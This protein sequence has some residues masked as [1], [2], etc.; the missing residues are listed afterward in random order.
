MSAAK[1]HPE[2]AAAMV[3]QP[4]GEPV[5]YVSQASLNVASVGRERGG[6]FDCHSWSE[7]PTS[8]HTVPL[9]TAQP[10]ATRVPLTKLSQAES[11]CP[12]TD[13]SPYARSAWLDGW[14][15]A[16][17]AHGITAVGQEGGAT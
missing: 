3:A 13:Q 14:G 10:A 17:R 12:Y 16:E 4:T 7:A 8:H 11:E 9:Y 1:V 5:A 2:V 15:A 6:P